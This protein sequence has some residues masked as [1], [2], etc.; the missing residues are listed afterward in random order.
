MP[1]TVRHSLTYFAQL[2]IGLIESESAALRTSP[3]VDF[4]FVLFGDRLAQAVS[5]NSVET[6]AQK[7]EPPAQHRGGKSA[8][9][10]ADKVRA[11]AD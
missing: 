11:M 4:V 8:H 5:E 2:R 7:R 9:E 6:A 1:T 10:N 3:A